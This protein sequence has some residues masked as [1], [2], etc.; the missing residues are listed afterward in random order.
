MERTIE[1]KNTQK[2]LNSIVAD[3]YLDGKYV[4]RIMDDIEHLQNANHTD[5][6]LYNY[7]RTAMLHYIEQLDTL[8]VN[9]ANQPFNVVNSTKAH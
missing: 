2:N 4:M 7:F 5:I 3:L 8:S 9:C 1:F 6:T